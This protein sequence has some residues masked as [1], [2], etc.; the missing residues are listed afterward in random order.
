MQYFWY[1][2]RYFHGF[3]AFKLCGVLPARIQPASN[4]YS[5]TF[6]PPDVTL[7]DRFSKRGTTHNF[8]FI[9][10]KT[11]SKSSESGFIQHIL[12]AQDWKNPLVCLPW[13]VPHAAGWAET[14][15]IAKRCQLL[16]LQHIL[17]CTRS[18]NFKNF[19]AL[20]WHSQCSTSQLRI[21]R[22][23]PGSHNILHLS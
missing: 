23:W 9:T 18:D 21:F 16:N 2:D 19:P 17:W 12:N 15:N 10:W 6:V 4:F 8:D 13:W 14:V 22:P 11:T 20:A 3:T 5:L 1:A 7:C